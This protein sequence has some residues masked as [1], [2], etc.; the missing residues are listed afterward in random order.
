MKKFLLLF[1][2]T[3]IVCS[4][5]QKKYIISWE[6]KQTL[7]AGNYTLEV[8]SFNKEYF[9]Y[10]FEEGLQFV[11]QWNVSN[12][13]NESSITINNVSYSNIS[14]SDLGNLDINKL[15]TELKFSLKNSNS[16]DKQYAFLKVSPII[17]NTDGS[18]KKITSFQITYNET[19]NTNRIAATNKSFGSLAVSNSVLSTGKWFKF[20]VE[21]AGVFQLSKNFIRQLGVD[22]D[23][24]DPRTIKIY[25]NGGQMIPY[26]NAVA[27]PFD[28]IE[29]A[30]KFVGEADGVFNNED[31][32][33]FYAQGPKEFNAESNTHINCYTDKT[34]YYINVG[35]G[36]G[37][38]IQ[39]FIQPSGAVDLEIDTFEDYQFHEVDENNLASLGRRWFG[40]RFDI[41][42]QKTFQ[43][44]VPDLITTTP[45]RLKVYFASTSTTQSSLKI[46]V[47]GTA[48][49][50]LL[51][52]GV[53]GTNLANETTR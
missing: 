12:L 18:F 50:T 42:N 41:Q 51:I 49:S 48:V 38:R 2:F 35:T 52:S 19:A 14:K 32:I 20:Y 33:L 11:D 16:R 17:K 43:F 4:S 27:Q 22:V 24:V 15:P 9:S 3:S 25:G 23:N 53:S 29:N 10:E 21:E 39:P 26:S 44:D 37:K 31:Y 5:Q 40:D 6:G 7:S 13:I 1:L 36:N 8:P 30:I 28:I 46:D 47:N 34:Y 45:V